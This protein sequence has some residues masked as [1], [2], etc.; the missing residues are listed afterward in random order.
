MK[1]LTLLIPAKQEAGSLPLVLDE[2]KNYNCTK[3][4]VLSKEDVET[5]EAIKKYDCKIFYQ[6]TNGYGSALIEGINEINTDYLCIF[7]ADGSF[8]PINLNQMLEKCKRGNDFVFASRYSLG[9][10]TKDDTFIT[11]IGNKIFSSIGK[12]FFSLNIDDILF[13]YV[14]GKTNSFKNLKLKNIDFSF[15]VELPIKAKRNKMKS[16]NIGSVERKRLKGF[17]KV[18]EFKDGF[19]ILMELLRLFFS[20][21]D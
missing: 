17:K 2:L 5:I 15:C 21:K 8:D 3:L 11:F 16:V 4:I 7:N 10:S 19:L 6:K 12:I 13:T 9:G 1:D 18:N 20:K 14:L